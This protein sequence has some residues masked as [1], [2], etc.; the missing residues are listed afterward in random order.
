[1]LGY[2][3]MKAGTK[4]MRHNKEVISTLGSIP[5]RPIGRDKL[6]GA[7][8]HSWGFEGQWQAIGGEVTGDID[9]S[10]KPIGFVGIQCSDRTVQQE[11]MHVY[12]SSKH[13][14]ETSWILLKSLLI[15]FAWKIINI[16]FQS[17]NWVIF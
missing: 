7:S 8:H 1:M 11:P 13:M 9:W 14:S 15:V 6:N 2:L 10:I 5:I 12:L 17:S 16:H 4:V 3:I